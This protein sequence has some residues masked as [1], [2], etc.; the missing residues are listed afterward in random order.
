MTEHNSKISSYGSIVMPSPHSTDASSRENVH[1]LAH[2]SSDEDDH[3]SPSNNGGGVS[4]IQLKSFRSNIGATS[5]YEWVTNKGARRR[6]SMITCALFLLVVLA[7]A[8]WAALW[9]TNSRS[10][11]SG[12]GPS[13]PVVPKGPP[14]RG[15]LSMLDPVTDL[16]LADYDRPKDSRIPSTLHKLADEGQRAFPTNA[17][18]QNMIMAGDQPSEVH[19]AYVIPYVV[20]AAG[21]I[22]GL[23]VHPNHVGSTQ[24]VVQVYVVEEYGLTVGAASDASRNHTD[25]PLSQRYYVKHATNMGVTLEWVRI[26]NE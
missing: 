7:A 14:Y 13:A 16:G 5:F 11:P 18:Y 8:A 25:K 4:E 22:P 26:M 23:R 9:Y 15:P 12:F 3:G 21:P 24:D 20:D 6:W 17:W 1:L 2:E 19:R 10:S